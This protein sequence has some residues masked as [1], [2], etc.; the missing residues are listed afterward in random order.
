MSYC[1]VPLNNDN[2]PDNWKDQIIEIIDLLKKFNVSNND[3]WKNNFLVSNNII[4]LIDFGWATKEHYFPYINITSEDVNDF[5]NIFELLD[6]VYQRVVEE[7]II[8]TNKI[9]S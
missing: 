6:H 4:Y 1:G 3:M 7:R 9:L 2:I 5:N 8:F